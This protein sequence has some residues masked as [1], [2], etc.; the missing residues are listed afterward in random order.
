[1]SKRTWFWII[2]LAGIAL[3]LYGITS[4]LLDNQA[5]RQTDT[6]SMAVNF[7]QHGFFP[8]FPQLNYDGPPPNYV[9]LEFPLVPLITAFL[10]QIFGQSDIVARC[11]VI[12]FSAVTFGF[13]YLLAKELYDQTSGLLAMVFF[14]LNPLAIYIGRA[15]MPDSA[16]LCLMTASAYFIVRWAK[17]NQ[18]RDLLLSAGTFALAGLAK[19]PALMLGAPLMVPFW[20]KYKFTVWRQKLL[21]LFLVIGL[22]PVFVYYYLAHVWAGHS[23]NQFVSGIVSSQLNTNLF[24]FAYLRLA[25]RKMITLPLIFLA[26]GGLFLR[27]SQIGNMFLWVW[28]GLLFIYA[29]SIGARIQLNYYLLPLVPLLSIL[30]G[31]TLGR[32]WSNIIAIIGS[33][34]IFAVCANLAFVALRDYYV[35]DYSYLQQAKLIE[36]YTRPNDLLVLDDAPPMTFYYSD[37]KGWRL[38]LNQQTSQQLEI[39]KREGAR[40]FVLLPHASVSKDLQKYLSDHYLFVKKGDFYDLQKPI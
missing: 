9:E 32:F 28:T 11:V 30:A 31:A 39:L 16:M 6:A 7:L 14:A 36:K 20:Q 37:R 19:L 35:V 22:I 15:V 18:N 8:P 2:L 17:N 33:L 25:V 1:M 4:P 29:I 24:G 27:K 12:A 26:V 10:W 38:P 5:W 3:R 21:W 23:V 34:V 13:V 40:L